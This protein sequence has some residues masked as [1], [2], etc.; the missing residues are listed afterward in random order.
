MQLFALNCKLILF[1]KKTLKLYY[2]LF[3]FSIEHL[4]PEDLTNFPYSVFGF[5]QPKIAIV[6][7]PNADFNVLFD[8]MTGFRHWDHKFEWTRSQ[9]E[10]W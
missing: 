8:N 4:Y 5:I 3:F 10:D 7:T 2:L 9:F 6:T 1:I